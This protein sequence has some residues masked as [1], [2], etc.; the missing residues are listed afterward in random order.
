M[1]RSLMRFI[2]IVTLLLGAAI[3]IAVGHQLLEE[4]Q[5]TSSHITASLKL[6]QK[7]HPGHQRHL[8]LCPQ[9]ARRCQGQPILLP[10]RGK[11]LKSDPH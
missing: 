11:S 2:I 6:A 8:C 4:V 10:A 5:T 9:Q 3:I 7:Q 1:L